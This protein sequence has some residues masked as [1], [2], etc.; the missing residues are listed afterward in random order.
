MYYSEQNSKIMH[1]FMALKT[2]ARKILAFKIL[3]IYKKAFLV[4]FS[5]AAT[6]WLTSLLKIHLSKVFSKI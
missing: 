5:K 6:C 4:T 2:S 3:S 1:T